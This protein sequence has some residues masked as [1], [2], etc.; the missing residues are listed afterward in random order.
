MR[1]PEDMGLA[2]GTQKERGEH[3][4]PTQPDAWGFAPQ[5]SSPCSWACAEAVTLVS[6]TRGRATSG[7]VVVGI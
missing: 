3:L 1:L 4:N 6:V 2:T 5:L 7:N